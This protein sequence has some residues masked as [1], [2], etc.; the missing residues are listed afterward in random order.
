MSSRDYINDPYFLKWIFRPDDQAEQHW[1]SYMESHPD[2]KAGILSLK[3]ELS[4]LKLKNEDLSENEKKLLIEAIVRQKVQTRIFSVTRMLRSS[5]FR[6]AAVAVI[7]LILGNLLNALFRD[8]AE[9]HDDY[10]ELTN[11]I[12]TD[13]PVMLLADGREINL[14][15]NSTVEYLPNHTIAVDDRT[16]VVSRAGSQKQNY[17]QVFIPKGHRC[18]LILSDRSVI[19]L[20]AGSK[21]VYPSAFDDVNR[22]VV[23]AGEAF[24][25]VSKNRDSPFIVRTG[26]LAVEVF[27]TKFNVSAY[28]EDPVIQ[29]VLVEG[30]VSVRRNGAN[31]SEEPILMEPEQMVTYNRQTHHFETNR[32]DPDFFTLWKDGILKFENEELSAVARKLERFYNVTVIFR[33]KEK[34]RIK[35]SGKL[36]LNENKNKVLEYLETLTGMPL[37]KLNETYYVIN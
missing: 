7:F 35:I 20:N 16:I 27:G 10:T 12:R 4:F 23:L 17:D 8:K 18:K 21:F 34:G 36:D 37:N 3:E 14:G 9:R 31:S 29:T 26:S 6:Y 11:L 33:D 24:F 28:D 32:V 2:E 25:E 22:E 13:K 15:T 5:Y 30:E 1:K 19:Y